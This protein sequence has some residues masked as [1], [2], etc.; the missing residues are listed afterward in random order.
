MM[1]IDLHYVGA[2]LNPYLLGNNMIHDDVDAKGEFKW[3]LWK[4]LVDAT[5]YV[6]ALTDFA[7]L[8]KGQGPFVNIP[9][10]TSLNMLL[11]VWWDLIGASIRTL[12]PIVKHI[13][14]QVCSS[15]SCE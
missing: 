11:H 8:V 12:A 14:A 15:S 1:K 6:Q 3:V 9:T 2:L 4:M 5:S 13:L 7:D 10:A